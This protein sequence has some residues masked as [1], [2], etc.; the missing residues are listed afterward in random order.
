[1]QN[2]VK[3]HNKAKKHS[4]RIFIYKVMLISMALLILLSFIFITIYPY[5]K[6]IQIKPNQ[7]KSTLLNRMEKASLMLTPKIIGYKNGKELYSIKADETKQDYKNNDLLH[8]KNINAKF[9]LSDTFTLYLQTKNGDFY[10]KDKYLNIANL[11]KIKIINKDKIAYLNLPNAQIY[12][13]QN[14]LTSKG[15]IK[16][17]NN[18]FWLKANGLIITNR[19][20]NILFTKKV[21]AHLKQKNQIV[22]VK[23]EQMEIN[24]VQRQLIWHNNVV[25]HKDNDILKSDKLLVCYSKAKHKDLYSSLEKILA[26]GNVYIK[27]NGQIA[28]A[29]KLNFD[30]KTNSYNLEKAGNNQQP[31]IFLGNE[32]L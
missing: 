12:I 24:T 32:K 20:D 21:F 10:T 26:T 22:T 27:Q 2:I 11:L 3:Q 17:T 14:K 28:K 5:I 30:T 16:L 19:G 13:K 1:M 23:A 6:K 7:L 18:N 31:V 15:Q 29:E 8:L 9:V 4:R 25:V